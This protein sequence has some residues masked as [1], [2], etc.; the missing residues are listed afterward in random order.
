[1]SLVATSTNPIFNPIIAFPV[2]KY[3]IIIVSMV[4]KNLQVSVFKRCLVLGFDAFDCYQNR[5]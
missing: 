1:M 5:S 2:T 3:A 4:L